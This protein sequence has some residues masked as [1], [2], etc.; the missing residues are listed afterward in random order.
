[1]PWVYMLECRDGSYYVGSTTFLEARVWQHQQGLGARYT[2]GRLPVV[3]AWAL[4]CERVDDA[5]YLEK[6]IQGWSRAKRRALIEG[7]FEDLPGLSGSR[8][9]R[10]AGGSMDSTRST[11]GPD[12]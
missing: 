5:Y 6:Q 11:G 8:Y 12:G 4:E 2:A 3:L 1:M 7:R 9:R 10:E